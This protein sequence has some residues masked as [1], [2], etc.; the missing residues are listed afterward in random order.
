MSLKLLLAF[1]AVGYGVC[2]HEH[3]WAFRTS[4]LWYNQK[5]KKRIRRIIEEVLRWPVFPFR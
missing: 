1:A 2:R 5:P 4:I 3:S